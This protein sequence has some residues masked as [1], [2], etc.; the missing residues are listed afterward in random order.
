MLS[1]LALPPLLLG[2][3]ASWL[4]AALLLDGPA[5]HS[6]RVVWLAA[7]VAVLALVR[8]IG[9]LSIAAS[10][11]ALVSLTTFVRL[12]QRQSG[13][14][15]EAGQHRA[16][17]EVLGVV[18]SDP[19]VVAGRVRGI[20]RSEDSVVIEVSVRRITVQ[21]QSFRVRGQLKVTAQGGGWQR[22]LPSQQIGFSG[23]AGLPREGEAFAAVLTAKGDPRLIGDPS[24]VQRV[25]AR[26][27]DGLSRSTDGLATEPGGLLP[28]LVDG[29][30]SRLDVDVKE[31][32]RAT[33]LTHLTAVSGSNVAIVLATVL[34]IVGLIGVGPRVR[35]VLAVLGLIGFVI[36]ARPSPSVMR[37][38]AMGAVVLLALMV[39]RP[40]R[41][42]PALG[43]AIVVLLAYDPDLARSVGF[44]LSSFA[45]AGIVILTPRIDERL[46]ESWPPWLRTALAV[47]LAAQLACAP[48][49]GAV[50]GTVG[51]TAIPANLLAAP[52][53]APATLAG[54]AA[55]G[56][57]LIWMP[58]ARV[59][60]ELGGY[61][62]GWLV[63][64]ADRLARVHAG[65]I[66]LPTGWL[67][68][69][70][71]L[72]VTVVCA[73]L[74]V[75][76]RPRRALIAAL[77]GCSFAGLAVTPH[78]V[79]SWPPAGWSLVAC[80][81]GQGDALVVR[82]GADGDVL[83]DTGPDP[84][85]L[86]ACLHRLGVRRLQRVILTHLHADHAEGLRAVLGEIPVG[87]VEVGPLKEPADEWERVQHWTAGSGVPI[88]EAQVGERGTAGA[89]EWEVLGPSRVLHGTDSDPNNAS[90][91]L[92]L[93]AGSIS[94]LLTGDVEDVSQS[95][96]LR[97]V[98]TAPIEA[99]V[100]KV[101]HHG[102]AKQDPAFL[103]Q[104]RARITIT[105]VGLGNPYGHPSPMT[106]ARVARSGGAV[107]RTDLD[108]SVAVVRSRGTVL[109]VPSRKREGRAGS[110]PVT[111]ST[112]SAVRSP[113]VLALGLAPADRFWCD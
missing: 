72:L 28:G 21:S 24:R 77:V 80:D 10:C 104:V 95:Q 58:L 8:R 48:V 97:S 63:E 102:S 59:A 30:T 88:V 64:V 81:V 62:C 41:S 79:E 84:R 3:G 85:A 94:V 96:L 17:I 25:A 16:T 23:K 112:S 42:L 74:L 34:G 9:W 26:L 38:A 60:A 54:V 32:F 101:P 61:C 46:P 20:Q 106:L 19:R 44:A 57:S 45:T 15:H 22:L 86:T 37:A 51:L 89:A 11:I 93:R 109:A 29:D 36:V 33:G 43:A 1:R 52:A 107:L 111:A 67:G 13:P 78:V 82:G 87:A 100:L 113:A 65:T 47:P 110:P 90:L 2:A 71:A 50:F 5:T 7:A 40:R 53:V 98:G 56:L 6:L 66:T 12:E 35:A 69:L 55:A 18:A 105:S 75:R 92:A 76:H 27:R 49:I 39:G 83:I 70:L 91:V 108:G 73:V 103:D 31:D 14:L 99:D 4:V 68:A